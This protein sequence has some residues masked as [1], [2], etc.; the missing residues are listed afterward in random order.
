[1]PS[2]LDNSNIIASIAGKH[3]GAPPADAAAPQPGAQQPAPQPAAKSADPSPTS[4]ERAQAKVAPADAAEDASK[5]A[6][7]FLK[8]G[9]REYTEQQIK[10]TLDRY[11]DLNFR[12]Q[13]NKPVVDVVTRL[14]ENARKNGHDPKPDEVAGLVDA[15]VNAFLKN[16]QMGGQKKGDSKSGEGKP[17]MSGEANTNL[18]DNDD[19]DSV[20]SQWETENA[21]K[22][23]PGFKETAKQSK[24]MSKKL[25]QVLSLF[26]Q[27]ISGGLAGQKSVDQASQQ[28]QQAQGM[29][30]N[31]ATQMITNNL[32]VAFQQAG[33]SVDPQVRGDFRMFAA[34]RG[35]DFPDFMDAGLTATVV[36]DYKANKDAPEIAR[37]RSVAQKRQAFTG[38]VEGAPGAGGGAAPAAKGDPMLESLVSTAMQ[39]RGI[40]G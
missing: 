22:L 6:V 39:K 5:D 25:D 28:V 3:L 34:Q 21:V 18:G 19:D 11:R 35:Y 30:A 16:P 36:A 14:V 10:G 4:M 1:M 26:D 27:I 40:G 24:E 15:A 32:N 37:L 13:S 17:A 33:I 7:S 2:E 23:P 9:D 38:M 31:A 20:Y 29:Q 8:V 12:W